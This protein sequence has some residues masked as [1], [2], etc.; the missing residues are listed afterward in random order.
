MRVA[1]LTDTYWPELNGAARTLKRWTQYLCKHH[2]PIRVIAPMSQ[3]PL[4]NEWHVNRVFSIPVA[5]YPDCRFALP[6]PSWIGR[7]LDLFNPSIIH[8]AT[9]FSLGLIGVRYA[10]SRGIPL[11]AS[12]HTHFD[13]YL[14]FYH[15]E[16]LEM[17]LWKYMRWFHR[18]CQA[19]YAP[20]TYTMRMLEAQGW[21]RLHVWTRGVD[22]Q[23]F[24]PLASEEKRL[25]RVSLG[26][27]I[28]R[29]IMLYVG[30]M[31]AEKS[32]DLLIEAYAALPAV[33]LSKSLLVLV[34]DGPERARLERQARLHQTQ[35]LHGDGAVLDI[36]FVDF[37]AQDKLSLY[38]GIADW[39]VFPSA[40]ETFGNV[41]LEAMSCGLPVI[42]TQSGAAAELVISDATGWLVPP[43]DLEA[44][45]DMLLRAHVESSRS[46]VM[47]A[48][49]RRSAERRSWE[50][51][52]GGMLDHYRQIANV[53]HCWEA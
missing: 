33:H 31:A 15:L 53:P 12:Y 38:Y 39:F 22:A 28:D 20:S 11:V 18:D 34:G 10:R 13:Q 49:G 44:F 16:S 21:N 41:I 19:V 43:Y 48:A 23:L 42:T 36:R 5:V 35:R 26:M 37:Q 32:V 7:Q 24:K 14:K 1:L 47:G 3:Q 29:Q 40:S 6:N 8:V 2:V 46:A 50:Q 4:A 9:P 17:L 52:F 30:R 27:P 51:V 25:R 45:K